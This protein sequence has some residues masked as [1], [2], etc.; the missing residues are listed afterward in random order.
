MYASF[1]IPA[2]YGGHCT[3]GS[4]LNEEGE[5]NDGGGPIYNSYYQWISIYL[6]FMAVLFLIPKIIWTTI[7]GG[8]MKF[9]R[10]GTDESPKEKRD[11]LLKVS[12][13]LIVIGK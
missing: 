7:E 6:S 2:E 11:K 9:I 3:S 4:E 13:H 1:H 10:K 5:L 12:W 8:V